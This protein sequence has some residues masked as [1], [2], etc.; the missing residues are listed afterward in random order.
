MSRRVGAT[1]GGPKQRCL[2]RGCNKWEF[3]KGLCGEC[4]RKDSTGEITAL[5]NRDWAAVKNLPPLAVNMVVVKVV[6]APHML[7]LAEGDY[8]NVLEHVADRGLVVVRT[9]TEEVGYYAADSLKTEEQIYHEFTVD[10]DV[11]LILE[12]EGREEQE[13]KREAE[14]EAG[15]RQRMML[16]AEEERKA[17]AEAE[18]Q[19]REKAERM[20]EELEAKKAWEEQE[21]RQAAA[22]KRQMAA[23]DAEQRRWRDQQLRKQASAA[24]EADE[25]ARE[26]KLNQKAAEHEAYLAS[27]E[28]RKDK[29]YLDSLPAWKRAVVLRKREQQGS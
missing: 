22:A 14:F 13:R 1:S 29:E 11:Q 6:D 28:A 3:K 12:L 16:K 27:E 26:A 18:R 19:A 10:E 8:V 7:E 15:L 20:L 2:M 4:S 25:R 5:L 23:K 9:A 17:R 24:R 21:A